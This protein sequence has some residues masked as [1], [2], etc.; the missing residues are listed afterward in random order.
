MPSAS[1]ADV[2]QTMRS[3]C[4]I[5]LQDNPPALDCYAP[6]D[7]L[8]AQPVDEGAHE[9]TGNSNRWVE[10]FSAENRTRGCRIAGSNGPVA[11]AVWP[12]HSLDHESRGVS[13]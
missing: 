10:G 3:L 9:P 12:A 13:G 6:D 1:R 4:S 5:T 2:P 11:G 7:A 8:P